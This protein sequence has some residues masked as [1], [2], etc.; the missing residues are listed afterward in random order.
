[1]S[2]IA[3]S[4]LEKA[5]SEEALWIIIRFKGQPTEERFG[6]YCVQLSSQGFEL[7]YDYRPLLYSVAGRA[8]ASSV[9]ALLSYDFVEE[10]ELSTAARL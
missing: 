2:P 4:Y 6:D 9:K 1:M 8:R 5:N 10:I 7:K 3:L